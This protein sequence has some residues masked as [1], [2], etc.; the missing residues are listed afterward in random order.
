MLFPGLEEVRLRRRDGEL[1]LERQRPRRAR[2]RREGARD[3][4]ARPRARRLLPPP[5][6][7]GHR[8]RP[9]PDG[10]P[11]PPRLQQ[12]HEGEPREAEALLEPQETP[13]A[14]EGDRTSEMVAD[15]GE[16][17]LWEVLQVRGLRMWA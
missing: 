7:E 1:P 15:S 3:L 13:R 17:I 2:A 10:V 8:P 16:I 4:R 6:R 9:S 5:R 11:A 14:R 12:G